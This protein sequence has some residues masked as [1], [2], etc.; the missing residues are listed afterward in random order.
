MFV[1]ID[2]GTTYTKIAYVDNRGDLKLFSYHDGIREWHY[3]RTAI[4]ANVEK[5]IFWI[6]EQAIQKAQKGQV[7]WFAEHFKMY[8]PI[9]KKG[10]T[11]LKKH[12]WNLEKPPSEV[13]ARYLY[14]L[15][16]EKEKGFYQSVGEPQKIVVSIPEMWQR[17]P[18]NPGAEILRQIF[19]S[20]QLGFNVPFEHLISE[21][22][23]AAAYFVYQYREQGKS[24]GSYNLLLCDIGGGTFDLALCRI[25][26]S[27]I[28]VIDFDG[29]GD[30]GIESGGVG[31]DQRAIRMAWK[32]VNPDHDPS[33][34][35]LRA[36]YRVFEETKI[37]SH[38]EIY[39]LFNEITDKTD[40]WDTPV[41]EFGEQSRYYLTLK[42]SVDAFEPIGQGLRSALERI[43]NRANENKVGI[44]RVAIVGG[45]GQFPLVEKIILESVGIKD[46]TDRRFDRT[47]HQR[48]GRFYAVAYGAALI[49]SGKI[50][51]I[52]YYPHTLGII[53]QRASDLKE[54][55]LPIIESNKVIARSGE[56][57][58]A[59][60]IV[61]VVGEKS[62][63][64]YYIQIRGTGDRYR[65][66][67]PVEQF[68]PLGNYRVGARIDASN[69][70]VL[71]FESADNKETR[72][73]YRLGD[74]NPALII[75]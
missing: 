5:K 71:I 64:D 9:E 56:V 59:K 50:V 36:L 47:L 37:S 28:E 20:N 48:L 14:Q 23:C 58:F 53:V 45:F 2:F 51:P 74:I 31:F 32:N 1:G 61:K 55:F 52:E 54:E 33:E 46:S 29:S 43:L 26:G 70:G 13:T 30:Y 11:E 10:K 24:N 34:Q 66:S 75:E 3:I 41:Y 22:I 16:Y 27:N 8:L 65:L 60:H 15:L 35:E 63:I 17:S 12:G 40:L 57:K 69:L 62:R 68:P 44:D 4:A 39:R 42:Q 21:P 18:N 67:I 73:E 49:A 38:E 6:G 19:E 25:S 7:D 72:Y